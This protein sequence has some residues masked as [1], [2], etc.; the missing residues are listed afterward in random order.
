MATT[1]NNPQNP[2]QLHF[3]SSL[4]NAVRPFTIFNLNSMAP[5]NNTTGNGADANTDPAFL[6]IKETLLQGG[7][8]IQQ[9]IGKSI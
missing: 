1:S 8:K 4:L 7:I 6:R 2:T 5:V 9:Q 3:Y